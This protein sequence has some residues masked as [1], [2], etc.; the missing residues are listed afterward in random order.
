[1][2]HIIKLITDEEIFRFHKS[3]LNS[4]VKHGRDKKAART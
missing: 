4:Y 1:M 2:K 3:N